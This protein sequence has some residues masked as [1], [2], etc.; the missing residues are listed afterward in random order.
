MR[1]DQVQLIQQYRGDIIEEYWKPGPLRSNRFYVDLFNYWQF[2]ERVRACG[3]EHLRPTVGQCISRKVIFR[4]ERL[5]SY[6]YSAYCRTASLHQCISDL[7]E[8]IIKGGSLLL[9]YVQESFES[10]YLFL[11]SALDNIGGVGNIMLGYANSEDSF[12]DFAKSFRADNIRTTA[13]PNAL[14]LFDAA[15]DIN[16]NYRAQIA[17]RGRFA[18]LWR[19]RQGIQTPFAQAEFEKTGPATESVSWR[20]DI[21]EMYEGRKKILP[22]TQLC[23]QHLRI[24]EQAIDEVFR[25]SIGEIDSYLQ[26]HEIRLAEDPSRFEFDATR[27]PDNARWVLYRCNHENRPYLNMWFHDLSKDDSPTVCINND[28]RSGNITPMYYVKE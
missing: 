15:K 21:R 19:E 3:L 5:A 2:R 8:Q 4:H 6:F 16:E 18:T 12:S 13:H 20:K 14:G 7:E 17:H 26:R 22:M 1:D 23:F 11:G 27:R 10:F 24:I 9:F 25:I 28:C